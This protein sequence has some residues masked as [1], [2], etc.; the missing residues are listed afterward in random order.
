MYIKCRYLLQQ[1]IFPRI[2]AHPSAPSLP[3]L[4]LPPSL[5]S[6]FPFFLPP[7][8]PPSL[9]SFLSFFRSFVCLF[10][11]SICFGFLICVTVLSYAAKNGGGQ[12]VVGQGSF[13]WS[14]V[15]RCEY[16]KIYI[17]KSITGTLHSYTYFKTPWFLWKVEQ[18]DWNCLWYK[19]LSRTWPGKGGE[20]GWGE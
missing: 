11:L 17:C 7:S 13:Y 1:Y 15:R 14:E 8:L 9:P 10:V 18:K 3:S 2:N 16:K 12:K 19:S 5:L 6:F 20:G 4:I